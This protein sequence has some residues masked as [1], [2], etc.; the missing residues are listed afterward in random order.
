MN[1]SAP[2]PDINRLFIG[3]RM[4]FEVETVFAEEGAVSPDEA[5]DFDEILVLLEGSIDL[6]LGEDR[7]IFKGLVTKEI[8]AGTRHI[9]RALE[10]PTKLVIIHPDRLKK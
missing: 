6:Q 1:S 8:P 10:T 4:E 7:E 9:I 3:A 5:H 2:I